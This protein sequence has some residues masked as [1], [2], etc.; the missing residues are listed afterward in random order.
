MAQGSVAIF[1][2]LLDDVI[3]AMQWPHLSSSVNPMTEIL[4]PYA[5]KGFHYIDA[6]VALIDEI[7]EVTRNSREMCVTD[8]GELPHRL[9][10]QLYQRLH[11]YGGFEWDT[12]N[13]GTRPNQSKHF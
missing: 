8:L 5:R 6:Y 11:S 1:D 9:Y 13:F 3:S 12:N 10:F 7:E 4:N 2:A